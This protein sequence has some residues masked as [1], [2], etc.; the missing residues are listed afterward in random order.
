MKAINNLKLAAL[1][2]LF[3]ASFSFGQ[4]ADIV[5]ETAAGGGG[6]M[7]G[8]AVELGINWGGHEGTWNEGPPYCPNSRG[9]TFNPEVE[10]G[11][12]S[13]PAMD[14]WGDYDGDFFSPGTPENGF[15]LEL[16]GV[17]YSNN[18]N[19]ADWTSGLP[20]QEE[21]PGDLI[22][23]NIDGDCMEVEWEGSINGIDVNVLYRLTYTELYY[24][25][26]VTLTNTNPTD[27]LDVYYYRNL[28]PDN[29]QPIG[30]GFVTTNTVQ[31]QPD[32]DCEI[33]LV[34]AEQ[35]NLWDNYFGLGAVGP[36]FRVTYG[37]FT[38]RDAS[39]IWN[40]A[41]PFTGTEGSTAVGDQGI[42][43]A[44]YIDNLEAGTSEEFQFAV[45]MSGDDVDAALSNLYY[46]DYDGGGG[47][48]DECNPVVDTVEICPGGSTEITVD[49]PS[50]AAYDWVWTPDTDLTTDTGPTTT[51]S[52]IVTT[53]Y[54]V[55]GT[56]TAA[57]LAS[58]ISKDI[59]VYI[60]SPP[61]GPDSA[62]VI[63]NSLA[64]LDLTDY[65]IPDVGAGTWEE[66]TTPASGTF[67]PTSGVFT[68]L[69]VPEGIYT[70][71]YIAAGED[72][73]PD[74]TMEVAI[75]VNQAVT[76]GEDNVAALCN[77]LGE[78]IDLNTLLID[79]DA[80]GIWD[81]TSGSLAF[82]PITGV[83]NAEGLPGG[84]YT[85]TYT[86]N[87]VLPCMLDVSDFTVTV[88]EIPPVV[89]N[90]A[91]DFEICELDAAVLTG[92]GGMP[93]T[94]YTWD[95]G[96]TDGTSF[97]PA[98]G[99]VNYTVTATDPNGCV[100][101]DDVEI[102]V[103]PKPTIT[104]TPDETIGCTPFEVQFTS[105]SFPEAAS[106]NWSF[107]DGGGS[108][109]CG[110]VSYTYEEEGI[111]DVG[112][113]VTDVNG[114][115]NSILVEDLIE[116]DATPI[117]SFSYNPQESFVFDP[118]VT[119]E[120]ASVFADTYQ[121]NFGDNTG[122]NT[123]ENPTHSFPTTSGNK[124]YTVELTAF[125]SLGCTD[126]ATAKIT[127]KDPI[128]FYM[129]NIF[130]PDGDDYN[131]TF[132]PVFYSGVDPYDFHMV[133]FNRYGEIIFESY[134]YSKGWDGTYGS[135]GIVEDGTYV[136]QLEFRETASDKRHIHQGHV[137]ILR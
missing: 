100:N 89:A 39:D 12:V 69:D 63:C 41:P 105:T 135:R 134:D 51:A 22:G 112:L 27:E 24:T 110:A 90:A 5:P 29:N 118:D 80:G 92:S 21:I 33:A 128:I 130:T 43:L 132:Q 58:E 11:F 82:D 96:V 67:D 124:V 106:C 64:D 55:T 114:C 8:E 66:T 72:G 3:P 113:F 60:A 32:V 115:Y 120:N 131:E 26:K 14:G 111:F 85:F 127:I 81:E 40:A 44:Y 103:N 28:D 9:A 121:W 23:F 18:A 117:A 133:I 76:A 95:N 86:V 34:S 17:N 36:D 59:V 78:T 79:A 101:T 98:V 123:D 16:G 45:I 52:P 20:T 49:G 102:T 137:S 109:N 2:I 119:F 68:S 7:V 125:N 65:L 25:T 62:D 83:F 47:V 4:Y 75:T 77:D 71:D 42:S 38:N 94:I 1:G 97:N 15:G 54:T 104:L 30:W 31:A 88:N 10:H 70:F 122:Y 6:F 50:A 19:N 35:S 87:A 129:P 108:N 126:V 48:I 53:T 91:G 46:F 74:D 99:T 107:G 57:C 116:V 56:P 13:N 93:G 136:W 84:D 61:A 73:C 37:G